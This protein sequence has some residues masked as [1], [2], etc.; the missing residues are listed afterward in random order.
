MPDEREG[1]VE[2]VGRVGSR[3]ARIERIGSIG[4]RQFYLHKLGKILFISPR[5]LVQSS[6]LF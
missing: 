6:D 5:M 2:D 4:F 3:V 1:V